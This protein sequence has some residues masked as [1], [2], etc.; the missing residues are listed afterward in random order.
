MIFQ[1][2]IDVAVDHVLLVR[3]AATKALDLFAYTSIGNILMNFSVILKN[4]SIASADGP[5]CYAM[6]GSITALSTR[7]PVF[8]VTMPF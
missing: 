1:T 3:D 8:G 5:K 4:T 2:Y 6:I 7:A